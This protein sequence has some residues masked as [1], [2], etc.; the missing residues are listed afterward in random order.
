MRKKMIFI[1]CVGGREKSRPDA[2][3]RLQGGLAGTPFR[4]LLESDIDI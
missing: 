2:P 4:L 3:H 1:F